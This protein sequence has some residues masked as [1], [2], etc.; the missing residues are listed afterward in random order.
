MKSYRD[1]Q[2]HDVQQKGNVTDAFL[3]RSIQVIH[4]DTR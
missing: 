3:R 4:K 1:I 2:A